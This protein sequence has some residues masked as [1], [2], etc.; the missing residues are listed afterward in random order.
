MQLTED[1]FKDVYKNEFS[2]WT[3]STWIL[4]LSVSL[5]QSVCLEAY[6]KSVTTTF[7]NYFLAAAAIFRHF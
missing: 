4:N 7:H 3:T 6:R 1:Y 5:T 2:A